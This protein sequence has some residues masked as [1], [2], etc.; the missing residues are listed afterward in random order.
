MYARDRKEVFEALH[1][2]LCSLGPNTDKQFGDVVRRLTTADRHLNENELCVFFEDTHLMLPT[3][4]LSKVAVSLWAIDTD[5]LR[6]A[7]SQELSNFLLKPF[8]AFQKEFG[9]SLLQEIKLRS[10][11]FVDWCAP[12]FAYCSLQD[13]EAVKITMD[14]VAKALPDNDVLGGLVEDLEVFAILVQSAIQ[15]KTSRA[16]AD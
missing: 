7:D 15:F 16:K 5:P 6:A 14:Q 10:A 12:Q 11:P 2:R 13:T 1:V 8:A 3:E 4:Y 9:D